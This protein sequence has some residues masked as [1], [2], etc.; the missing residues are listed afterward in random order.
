[1]FKGENI[2]KHDI[3]E[4]YFR[5]DTHQHYTQHNINI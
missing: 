4:F 5:I 3:T 2:S 1:M